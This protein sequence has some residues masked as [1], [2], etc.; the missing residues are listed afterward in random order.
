MKEQKED[1]DDYRY[2]LILRCMELSVKM[3]LAL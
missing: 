1:I 3:V 2:Q